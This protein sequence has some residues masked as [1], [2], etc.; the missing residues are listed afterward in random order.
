MLLLFDYLEKRTTRIPGEIPFKAD[1]YNKTETERNYWLT[2][3][4]LV[5]QFLSTIEKFQLLS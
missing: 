4:I 2:S 3:H 5:L 1:Y